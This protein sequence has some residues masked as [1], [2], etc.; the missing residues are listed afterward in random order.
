MRHRRPVAIFSVGLALLAGAC[1]DAP[2]R[3]TVR[4]PL[5]PSTISPGVSTSP[6]TSP[7]ATTA[8]S[9]PLGAAVALP[10]EVLAATSPVVL[11]PARNESFA[12]RNALETKYRD[13]LRRT[14]TS[15]WVDVEGDV[16]WTQEYLRYRVNGCDHG[17]S[18]QRVM[19]QIDGRGAGPTCA[20]ARGGVVPFP[21]RDE[22]FAFRRDLEVKYRDGLRR[23]ASSTFVDTEGSL[24]WVQEY[25]R[26]RVNACDHLASESKVM[27]QIDG[28]GIAPDCVPIARPGERT[29]TGVWHGTSEFSNAPFEMTLRQ[30][31]TKVSGSYQD[32][33]DEGSVSDYPGP[34]EVTLLIRF[35][36]AGLLLRG[37]FVDDYHVVGTISYATHRW[38]M[39]MVK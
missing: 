4:G 28:Q 15:T 5:A 33:N 35:A 20:E 27:G 6:G 39:Q 38:P 29:L 26:Y 16:V 14:A 21:P 17:L 8:G 31:G 22:S 32:Q 2:R 34:D 13:G 23:P 11:F 37:R 1:S 12:F 7:S 24:V 19:D 3:D 10:P 18:V 36:D 25:L 30:Q 9:R